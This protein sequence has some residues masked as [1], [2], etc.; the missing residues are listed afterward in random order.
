MTVGSRIVGYKSRPD[1]NTIIT[2]FSRALLE[3]L[4]AQQSDEEFDAML[5]AS[6][7]GIYQ[8]SST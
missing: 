5:D 2:S 7:E 3:G 1:P 6:I 4:N 8:A